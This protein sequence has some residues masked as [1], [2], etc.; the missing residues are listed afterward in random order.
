M[1]LCIVE[2]MLV[3]GWMAY[4]AKPTALVVD[5]VVNRL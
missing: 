2:V 3:E 1:T 5:N 4:L